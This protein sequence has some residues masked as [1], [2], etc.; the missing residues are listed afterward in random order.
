MMPDSMFVYM[1]S[2][3]LFTQPLGM[4]NGYFVSKIPEIGKIRLLLLLGG[5]VEK[6]PT[7]QE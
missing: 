6:S 1:V 3:L 4:N 2:S 5:L 7:G